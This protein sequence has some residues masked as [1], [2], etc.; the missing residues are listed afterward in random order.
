MVGFKYFQCIGV[1]VLA[2]VDENR[3]DRRC[4]FASRTV[5]NTL[6]EKRFAFSGHL[7]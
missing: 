5:V 1:R 7:L 3:I 6:L 2:G 4:M